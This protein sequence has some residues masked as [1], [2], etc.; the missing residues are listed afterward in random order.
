M[1]LPLNIS[2]LFLKK[3]T[4]KVT[5][6]NFFFEKKIPANAMEISVLLYE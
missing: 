3:R 5:P 6:A 2:K 4:K 1:G